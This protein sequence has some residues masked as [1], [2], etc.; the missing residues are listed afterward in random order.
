MGIEGWPVWVGFFFFF[1]EGGGLFVEDGGL[2]RGEE[3][4]LW[5]AGI[6]S[7]IGWNSAYR[8]NHSRECSEQPHG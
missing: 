3:E 2:V 5:R 6:T 1:W 8:V 7:H 4:C